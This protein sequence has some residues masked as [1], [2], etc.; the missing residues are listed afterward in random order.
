[1]SVF[2]ET[3]KSVVEAENAN[4]KVFS[5]K[6]PK[7]FKNLWGLDKSG[8]IPNNPI[9]MSLKKW[10]ANNKDIRIVI[11]WNGTPEDHRSGLLSISQFVTPYDWA[12]IASYCIYKEKC[13]ASYSLQ[14]LILDV[15]VVRN[16]DLA[17]PLFSHHNALPWVQDYLP[18]GRDPAD[19]V[20][21]LKIPRDLRSDE[22]A[23][24]GGALKFLKRLLTSADAEDSKDLLKYASV[25]Q[26]LPLGYRDFGALLEDIKA[27][28]LM[29]TTHPEG[30]W[31]D[32][33]AELE[34]MI[35]VW[36]IDLLK[37][38][39][40]HSAANLIG[41]VALANAL[42]RS[43]AEKVLKEIQGASLRRQ[44]LLSG[45]TQVDLFRQ[46]APG[47]HATYPGVLCTEG[48]KE[49]AKSNVFGRLNRIK[50]WLIDDQ[51]SLGYD[52][53]LA[54]VIGI[55][56]PKKDK[57]GD[58]SPSKVTFKK[59][60]S[61][62]LVCESN[63]DGLLE[64]LGKLEFKWGLPAYFEAYDILLLDLRLWSPDS[65][66]RCR[67]VLK[68]VVYKTKILLGCKSA[69]D[70]D[71]HLE[72]ALSSAEEVIK[73][74]PFRVE[75]LA[76]LPLLLS[77]IDR[78]L[79]IILFSSTRQRAVVEMLKDKP[80]IILEFT[81]PAIGIDDA[82]V[83]ESLERAICRAIELHEMRIAWK[84]ISKLKPQKR[85]FSYT[86]AG[87]GLS[88]PVPFNC[89]GDEIRYRIGELFVW[90]L[91]TGDT[92][93]PF[94]EIHKPWE[95]IE[96]L[97]VRENTQRV[98]GLAPTDTDEFSGLAR[99]LK[100]NRNDKT[101]RNLSREMF[102]KDFTLARQLLVLQLLFLLDFLEKEKPEDKII[103]ATWDQVGESSA[104]D[105]GPRRV[106]F[107]LANNVCQP[108]SRKWLDSCTESAL[109]KLCQTQKVELVK[110]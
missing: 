11:I 76:L 110:E 23:E 4:V 17:G 96:E 107:N 36:K 82:D 2:V 44:A 86:D 47:E 65:T 71:Q 87:N 85:C 22:K 7:D 104:R 33:K 92:R 91:D 101:H 63:V 15:R 24:S 25:R 81:K 57:K 100:D 75:A 83:L 99:A 98:R 12:K 102:D 14:F 109:R 40:R 8:N 69:G 18:V 84:R 105:K 16:R 28:Q 56:N 70:V 58:D 50:F 37:E 88:V 60:N 108:N 74:N 45:L 55:G 61:H 62:S 42:P 9:T 95:L 77:C 41:P 29:L 27:P 59:K 49:R 34:K 32:R 93:S 35:D 43:T 66:D 21:N 80:N 97:F 39:N 90:C 103:D 54:S 78:T 89:Y 26:A 53:V 52:Y 19:N 13:L 72:T 67:E 3:V 6:D 1:M 38:E 94:E 106:L 46:P 68:K 30:D 10:V 48:A 20:R 31:D 79:P 73:K 5:Y 51:F 64:E